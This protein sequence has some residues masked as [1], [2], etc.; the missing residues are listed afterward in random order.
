MEKIVLSCNRRIHGPRYNFSIQSWEQRY[1]YIYI[2][3]YN[4]FFRIQLFSLCPV[5]LAYRTF[6]KCIKKNKCTTMYLR[7]LTMIYRIHPIPTTILSPNL[8]QSVLL[9][10]LSS[11]VRN[12]C[13]FSSRT[14]FFLFFFL[15][16]FT[17][18]GSIRYTRLASSLSLF[19][20]VS[21]RCILRPATFAR[22]T[23]PGS[24]H[25]GE[26][27][28]RFFLFMLD[29]LST[30]ARDNDCEQTAPGTVGE[31]P[32][33][34]LYYIISREADNVGKEPGNVG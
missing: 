20:D 3:I 7:I 26:I 15:N 6:V 24:R 12:S 9:L 34:K 23:F 13:N 16:L 25:D 2:C 5:F 29:A 27:D 21:R 18:M 10:V 30:I 1:R 32:S 14:F 31:A 4:F 33:V 17:A 11:F 22:A 19:L 28:Q 8:Y